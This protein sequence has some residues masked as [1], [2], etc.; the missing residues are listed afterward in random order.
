MS[1][2]NPNHSKKHHIELNHL[3]KSSNLE[4]SAKLNEETAHD[5]TMIYIEG[6]SFLMGSEDDDAHIEDREGPV[7]EEIVESFLIDQT[8]VTNGSFKQFIDETGYQ[9]EAEIYGWSFVFH[10][11]LSEEVKSQVQNVP[12]QTPW[13]CVVAGANWSQPE[14]PGSSIED[15]MDHPVVHV[16]WN[17]AMAYCA[18]SGKRLLNEKEWEYAARGGLI[19]QRF[20]WGNELNPDQRHMCNI[21]Q[22]SFPS[23]NSAEDGYIGTSPV[24]AFPKNRFGLY[25]MAG[26]VWEWCSN[27]F[28]WDLDNVDNT[29]KTVKGGSYLCHDS[30]CNRYRVAARTSNTIDSSTGNMGFRCA[31]DIVKKSN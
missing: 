6:G 23:E 17:D 30:Y 26:N 8:A 24:K 27:N 25:G 22:G 7:R 12:A 29:S 9:T 16:S 11:L 28:D 18:W 15:R 5:D 1:C 10:L 2:C 4:F 31:K 14:G 13:W 19:Q 20:S 3:K 21:W